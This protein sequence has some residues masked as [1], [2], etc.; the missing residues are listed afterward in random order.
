VV[1]VLGKNAGSVVFVVVVGTGNTVLV[2]GADALEASVVTF[3]TFLFVTFVEVA[4]GAVHDASSFALDEEVADGTGIA[5]SVFVAGNTSAGAFDA[6][7][8]G[9]FSVSDRA[10]GNASVLVEF[11][12]HSAINALVDIGGASTAVLVGASNA[13]TVDL[14]FAFGAGVDAL[15]VV[16]A[17]SGN[18][19]GA[20]VFADAAQAGG[21]AVYAFS[22]S[23]EGL[24]RAGGRADALV[25]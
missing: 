6:G 23:G 5:S 2:S 19:L 1:A 12:G 18:T 11:S 14:D 24:L 15:V 25:K 16:K 7:V 21:V 4:V 22:G 10:G 20:D 17:E 9:S 3:S 13:E 8:V